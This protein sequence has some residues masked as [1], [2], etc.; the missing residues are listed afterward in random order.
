MEPVEKCIREAGFDLFGVLPVGASTTV[1]A[2][3]TWL[4]E[5]M[6]G[7]MDWMAREE[8]VEKR[9]HPGKILPHAQSLI[10]L[11]FQYTPYEIPAELLHDPSRGIIARYALYDDYHLVI[12]KKLQQLVEG[13]QR[14]FGAFEWKAYVDT[15][16]FLEREWAA[17]AGLGYIGRNSN[18][19]HYQLG[20]YL[21]LAELLVSIP[22]PEFRRPERG[23]CARCVRCIDQCPT[24]AIVADKTIDARKCISYITIEHRGAI[25]EWIRPLMKNRIYGCDI[26]QEVC[27]WNSGRAAQKKADFVVREDLVAPKLSTLLFFDDAAFRARFAR[28]PIKRAKREGFMRNVAVALGNWKS[29]EARGLLNSIIE[30]DP[31]P[32]VRE[33]AKWG[34][35]Y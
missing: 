9:S 8:T 30:E 10:T 15:G 17:A 3:K 29:D 12:Q 4:G 34:L 13:L 1:D 24:G 33:H 6:H 21:F 2:L 20:S 25:P 7:T 27:P 19:I 11:A 35:P 26:C 31:S 16:P 5:G 18:L 22:L 23:S 32:L 14:E 28:S